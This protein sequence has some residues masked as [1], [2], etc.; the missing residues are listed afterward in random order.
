MIILHK[1]LFAKN[2]NILATNLHD[3]H[4]YFDPR[5]LFLD[6][7]KS[8]FLDIFKTILSMT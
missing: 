8:K 4:N 6:R 7:F 5:K 1:N 2:F 3:L